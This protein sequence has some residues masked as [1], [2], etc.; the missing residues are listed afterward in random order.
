M[1][2][3]KEIVAYGQDYNTHIEL[4]PIQAINFVIDDLDLSNLGVS[5]RSIFIGISQL[6]NTAFFETLIIY[7]T[8]YKM[9]E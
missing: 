5:H 9:D 7:T 2:S 3:N 1:N 8:L 4:K 6:R